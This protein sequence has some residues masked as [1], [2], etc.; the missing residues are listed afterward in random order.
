MPDWIDPLFFVICFVGFSVAFL[1]L[2]KEIRKN[3]ELADG[4]NKLDSVIASHIAVINNQ[5]QRI[6]HLEETNK[7][8]SQYQDIIDIEA[9]IKAQKQAFAEQKQVA[10]AKIKEQVDAA[11]AKINSRLEKAHRKLEEAEQEKNRII[12]QAEDEARNIAGKAYDAAKRESELQAA[13]KA[14]ENSISG[15]NDSYLIPAET[16]LD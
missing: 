14:M 9:E 6:N 5:K 15:Y 4:I 8:L 13:I 16:L 12:R 10:I 2:F 3:K 1:K 7:N 11:N